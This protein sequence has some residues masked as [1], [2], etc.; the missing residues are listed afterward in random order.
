MKKQHAFLSI[1]SASA[2]ALAF[3]LCLVSCSK[4]D[5]FGDYDTD[6]RFSKSD[7]L[8]G[9]IGGESG[10][11]DDS[12]TGNSNAGILTAGEWNDLVH[13]SFWSRL[14]NTSTY[15]RYSGYWQLITNNRVPV[16]VTDMDGKAL[17][18]VKIELLRASSGTV[19]WET[20]TDNHGLADC[21]VGLY[22]KETV[23]GASLR[24]AVAGN[25]MEG[26]PTIYGWG[27]DSLTTD[28]VQ[29]QNSF[30]EEL[31]VY[32]TYVLADAPAVASSADIAF[33]VDATGSMADEIEFLKSDLY[34]IIT[35]AESVNPSVSIRTAALFYRDEGDD[36]V[37]RYSDFTEKVKETAAY[38]KEQN[39]DGGGDY[40]EAV[41]TA[42]E[43]ML[44]D[45][46]WKENARS[47]VAFL[48]LD[49]PA[50][51]TDTVIASLQA[52]IKACA[53][54]GIRII[55][56]AASGVDKNTEFMLRFFAIAT[57]GTYVFLTDDSG[58][59]GS[60]LVATVGD[61]KVEQ[62]NDLLVRLIAEY[63]E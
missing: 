10:E 57:G 9:E 30:V 48:I 14:M 16:K 12:Q 6:G 51:Y 8:S 17:P 47:K 58:V 45:L 4:D 32:N 18:G 3:I 33:V 40:P 27:T 52:S 53:R 59:G 28:T 29:G 62:L 43:H 21:W 60:H 19:V 61:Y 22:Q 38:V 41:H 56:V 26:V 55:P 1:V 54:N 44:Q 2:M 25:M 13:W 49:A 7:G 34:D 37:T 23:D 39:A 42:L 20:L 35:K 63:T 50:H 46:S 24:V 31:V 36:Y 5:V 15:D 11:V